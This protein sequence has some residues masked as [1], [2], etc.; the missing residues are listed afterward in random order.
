MSQGVVRKGHRG[1]M[2]AKSLSSNGLIS[3][4]H[5]PGIPSNVPTIP[6]GIGGSDPFGMDLGYYVFMAVLVLIVFSAVIA[7]EGEVKP[8]RIVRRKIG[9]GLV[10]GN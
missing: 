5:M 10:R 7:Y 3:F 6:L 4:D 9:R 1:G 2:P 8:S